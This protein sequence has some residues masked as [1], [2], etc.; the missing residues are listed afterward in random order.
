MKKIIQLG[1]LLEVDFKRSIYSWKFLFIVIGIC[2]V[3]LSSM[4]DSI[5]SIIR[6]DLPRENFSSV[7]ELMIMLNFDRFKTVI[8]VLLAGIYSASYCEDWNHRYFRLI[9][10]RSGLKI[11][12]LSRIIAIIVSVV[13]A[14]IL[15]FFLC[16]LV[17][18]PI[19]EIDMQEQDV[20]WYN[21]YQSLALRFPLGFALILGW[22]FGLCAAFLALFGLWMSVKQPNGFV[23]IGAPFL[24]FYFL[25]AI[26]M[27]FPSFLSFNAI[28]SNPSIAFIGNPILSFLYNTGVLGLLII[29]TSLGFYCSLRK[30]WKNGLF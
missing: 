21:A 8:I 3:C 28:T 29:L 26:S 27:L 12:T 5:S 23:A 10:C 7:R 17:L 1:S 19:M 13:L 16:I 4:T 30:R 2:A 18:S 25:Y 14:T 9:L 24:L 20:S 22:N 11:Y 6:F 15:G